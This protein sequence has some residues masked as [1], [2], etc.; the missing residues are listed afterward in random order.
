MLIVYAVKFQPQPDDFS[1]VPESEYGFMVQHV[2]YPPG[3][4]INITD[5]VSCYN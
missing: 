3:E 1:E 4:T 5:I 2:I